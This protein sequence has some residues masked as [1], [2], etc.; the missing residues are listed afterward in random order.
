MERRREDEP[1]FRAEDGGERVSCGG[2]VVHDDA[3]LEKAAAA[4]MT[5]AELMT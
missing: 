4:R 5:I 2:E 3:L 1:C